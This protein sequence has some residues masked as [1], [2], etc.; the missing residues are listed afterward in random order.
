MINF[1]LSKFASF[2]VIDGTPT[3]PTDNEIHIFT[4]FF[5]STDKTPAPTPTP[6]NRF[7][8]FIASVANDEDASHQASEGVQ[9]NAEIKYCLYRNYMN[10]HI[11]KI[12]LLN[13]R[14]YTDTELCDGRVDGQSGGSKIFQ[15]SIGK[16][17]TFED[18][19]KYIRE[20][21]ISGYCVLTNADIFLDN[22]LFCDMSI[23]AK[24]TYYTVLYLDPGSTPK[25]PGLY[26]I[27]K[28]PKERGERARA[29][30]LELKKS[31]RRRSI[32]NLVAPVATTNS[33]I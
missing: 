32:L 2:G 31:T 4:Q 1:E 9:R 6:A 8:N 24:Q 21:H 26:I 18:V 11:T 17:L 30:H 12:H 7:K 19:F 3:H 22:S 25:T 28:I 10:P 14:I 13:E 20:N 33:R 5:I 29:L 27:Q 23:V 15:T 16:R